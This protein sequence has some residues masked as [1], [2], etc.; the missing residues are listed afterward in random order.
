MSDYGYLLLGY[1][2]GLITGAI[3]SF[4]FAKRKYK[5]DRETITITKGEPVFPVEAPKEEETNEKDDA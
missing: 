1:F 2:A 5:G 3:I 4:F